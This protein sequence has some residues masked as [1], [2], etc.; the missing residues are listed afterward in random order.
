MLKSINNFLY[1]FVLFYF[2]KLKHY[3]LGMWIP[4]QKKIP[5]QQRKKNQLQLGTS[6]QTKMNTPRRITTRRRIHFQNRFLRLNQLAFRHYLEVLLILKPLERIIQTLI[7]HQL[8]SPK[9]IQSQVSQVRIQTY[10]LQVHFTTRHSAQA[11]Q[12]LIFELKYYLLLLS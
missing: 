7:P 9:E 2:C 5:G 8:A 12:N 1:Q 11:W 3:I 6:K 10:L 4:F